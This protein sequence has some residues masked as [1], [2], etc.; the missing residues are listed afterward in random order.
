VVS[1][2]LASVVLHLLLGL[3]HD[4][5]GIHTV[6]PIHLSES[7][8]T[9]TLVV[10]VGILAAARW[11]NR[12]GGRAVASVL[13][14]GYLASMALL[15]L[16]NLASLHD[17]ALANHTPH[18]LLAANG[19]HHAIV[20]AMPPISLFR[21]NPSYTQTSSWALHYPIP[22][23]WF[24]DD[25]IFAEGAGPKQQGADPVALHALFPDRT[26]WFLRYGRKLP[27]FSLSEWDPAA[28]ASP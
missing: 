12:H 14:A 6:G 24:R 22:D 9:L 16:P 23:P 19:V 18:E 25:V 7:A 20:I 5:T 11:A 2:L 1:V 26:I 17:E 27:A 4:D 8:V 15:Q 3:A 21:G 13:V 28:P 10:T